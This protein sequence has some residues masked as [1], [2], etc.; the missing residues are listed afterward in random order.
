M[1]GGDELVEVA[2]W[3]EGVVRGGD[4]EELADTLGRAHLRQNRLGLVGI[5]VGG[6]GRLPGNGGS[7]EEGEG[8]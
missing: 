1:V 2:V 6:N 4:E 5:G 3:G 7:I 8:K